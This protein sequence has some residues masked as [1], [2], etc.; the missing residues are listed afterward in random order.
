VNSEVAIQAYTTNF[1][2]ATRMNTVLTPLPYS[3][4]VAIFLRAAAY[5]L[6]VGSSGPGGSS[7]GLLGT[8][9]VLFYTHPS[10]HQNATHGGLQE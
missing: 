5:S 1:N 7:L 3:L 6:L 9:S 10:P 8:F 4:E 2:N